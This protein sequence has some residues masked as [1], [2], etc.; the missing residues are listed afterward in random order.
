MDALEN[1]FDGIEYEEDTD[2]YD[3]YDIKEKKLKAPRKRSNSRDDEQS[4]GKDNK[5]LQAWVFTL[6]GR[7]EFELHLSA[8]DIK[9]KEQQWIINERDVVYAVEPVLS[10][11]T[12][13]TVAHTL[14]LDTTE[15]EMSETGEIRWLRICTYEEAIPY[16][17][18]V[19]G[20][21]RLQEQDGKL[22]KNAYYS[23]KAMDALAA[24]KQRIKEKVDS[25][26]AC[27]V[28]Q[29]RKVAK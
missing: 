12:A 7:V 16:G 5:P 21:V 11:T 29:M 27:Y 26:I 1:I 4:K 15:K 23:N 2:Y 22:K 24:K 13:R 3:E 19:I 28:K 20:Y 9:Y 8:H 14:G 18:S 10:G 17:A 25:A 6:P